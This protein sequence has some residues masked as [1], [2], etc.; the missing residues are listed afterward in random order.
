M[1]NFLVISL[2]FLTMISCEKDDNLR[3][4]LDKDYFPLQVGNQWNFV[5]AGKDSIVDI[6]TIDG[7]DYYE[8]ANDY[9]TTSYYRK[10]DGRIYVKSPSFENKEEMK[11]DLAANVNATWKYGSG[12]VTLINRNATITI[13]DTQLD[14][15]LQFNFHNKNLMDYGSTVWLAPGIGL[16]Q[17]TCQE[18]F[19]STFETL[20]LEKAMIDN[21][22]I[23]FK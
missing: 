1:K 14:S 12:Y 16:I 3:I 5:L 23:E 22:L 18:C 17:Q 13:G 19:G 2:A 4:K 6:T 11:F 20:R 10:K 21:Q 8:F 7:N 9:G 15:C